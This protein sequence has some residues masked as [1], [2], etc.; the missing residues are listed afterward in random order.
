ME[1]NLKFKFFNSKEEYQNFINQWKRFFNEEARN[2]DRNIHG[3]KIIKL[4][5]MHFY[6]Y[7]ILRDKDPRKCFHS[8]EKFEDVEKYIARRL[9]A[10]VRSG[11]KVL[12][13]AFPK[14]TIER[15]SEYLF[16]MQFIKEQQDIRERKIGG[17]INE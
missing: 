15:L 8:Q 17:I 13:S 5:D 9:I 11:N 4:E 16:N 2:L 14:D 6:I 7:A 12:L 10:K 1:K 3:N